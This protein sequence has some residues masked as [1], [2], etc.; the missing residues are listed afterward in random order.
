MRAR[1]NPF[2]VHRVLCERYRF[3]RAEWDDVIAAFAARGFRG[4]IVGPHGSGKTTLLEDL[5]DRLARSGYPIHFIRLS[6]EIRVPNLTSACAPGAIVLCDGAEQLGLAD[7]TRLR[8]W[9]RRARGLI[10]TCHDERW[11]PVLLRCST[12]PILLRELV[13]SLGVSLTHAD[14]EQLHRRHAGNVRDA[15]RELYDACAAL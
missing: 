4:S 5:G 9:A 12:T 1:D 6:S 8:W 7:R 14:S 11:G 3:T 10:V 15:M 13:A 2:A